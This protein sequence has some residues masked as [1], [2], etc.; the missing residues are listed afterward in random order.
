MGK[1]FVLLSLILLTVAFSYWAIII[2]VMSG[3]GGGPNAT[4]QFFQSVSIFVGV[5]SLA[6]ALLW[7]Y[8]F[9][10]IRV[11]RSVLSN[12]SPAHSSV[13]SVGY[14]IAY[15]LVTLFWI[16]GTAV[17]LLM[18]LSYHEPVFYQILFPMLTAMIVFP[19]SLVYL[20]HQRQLS[21]LSRICYLLL[22]CVSLAIIFFYTVPMVL[23][24][25]V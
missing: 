19:I 9:N 10:R 3:M 25:L 21:S 20:Y 12:E 13:L 1:F 7:G 22:C 4:S 2:I 16:I 23:S 24:F 15:A 17:L 14:T 8:Y 11:T 6:L 5:P 18:V